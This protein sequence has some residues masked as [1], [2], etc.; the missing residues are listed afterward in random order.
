M[1]LLEIQ[2][3]RFVVSRRDT[4]FL[5]GHRLGQIPGTKPPERPHTS[6]DQED[7]GDD[8]DGKAAKNS[9]SC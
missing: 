9:G 8:D 3:C 7:E 6:R 5:T 4:S 1:C 2:N